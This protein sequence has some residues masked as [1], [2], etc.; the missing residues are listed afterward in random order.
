MTE[1]S[2]EPQPVPADGDG[3]AE[4]TGATPVFDSSPDPTT[5]APAGPGSGPAAGTPQPVTDPDDPSLDAPVEPDPTVSGD[6]TGSALP[7]VEPDPTATGGSSSGGTDDPQ[8]DVPPDAV[9]DP[10]A[11]T[12]N[13]GVT[14]T[15]VHE[16][17]HV[18]LRDVLALVE[19]FVARNPH[20]QNLEADLKSAISTVERFTV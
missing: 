3:T 4:P 1:T 10:E 13:G 18:R 9:Q 6:G 15:N 16:S 5:P 17:V 14:S 11:G 7:P 2:P 19:N 20:V 12:V 8:L